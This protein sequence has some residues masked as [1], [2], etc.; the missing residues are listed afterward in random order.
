MSETPT[1]PMDEGTGDGGADAAGH[2]GGADKGAGEGTGDGGADAAGHD[3]GADSG[4]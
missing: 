1:D 3:G 2:D 4:A